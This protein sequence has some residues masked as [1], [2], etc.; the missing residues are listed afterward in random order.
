[1]L[2]PSENCNVL[3]REKVV[4]GANG[5]IGKAHVQDILHEEDAGEPHHAAH[6][7]CIAVSQTNKVL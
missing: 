7:W 1:M 3:T 5:F 6:R 2:N 4:A